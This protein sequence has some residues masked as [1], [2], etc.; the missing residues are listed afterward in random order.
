MSL[1]KTYSTTLIRRGRKHNCFMSADALLFLMEYLHKLTLDWV[2]MALCLCEDQ[3]GKAEQLI[4]H[5]DV[6]IISSIH[7]PYDFV[8]GDS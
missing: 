8:Q 7:A 1:G 3:E 2:K 5:C 4:P 6:E